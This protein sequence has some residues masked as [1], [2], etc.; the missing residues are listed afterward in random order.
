MKLVLLHTEFRMW[1]SKV[2]FSDMMTLN[3]SLKAFSV[4]YNA[5]NSILKNM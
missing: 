1:S 2:L 4:L 5:T 3:Y